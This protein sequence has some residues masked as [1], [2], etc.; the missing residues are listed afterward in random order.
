MR[1]EGFYSGASVGRD[2][3]RLDSLLAVLR[4]LF[5]HR[6]KF[7][8]QSAREVVLLLHPADLTHHVY[9]DGYLPPRRKIQI[10]ARLPRRIDGSKPATRQPNVEF[11]DR[12][13]DRVR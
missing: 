7:L 9:R 13:T 4:D 11:G 1:I 8:H 2:L 5:G 12:S 6:N 3:P 10:I